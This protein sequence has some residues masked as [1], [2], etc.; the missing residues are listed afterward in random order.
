M[1]AAMRGHFILLV[2]ANMQ[3]EAHF[4]RAK[5]SEPSLLALGEISCG[6]PLVERAAFG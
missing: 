1:V 4:R 6:I 5:P 2:R 3:I